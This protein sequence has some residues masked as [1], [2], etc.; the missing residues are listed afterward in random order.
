MGVDAR[1]TLA[2]EAGLLRL[3]R[4]SFGSENVRRGG[5]KRNRYRGIADTKRGKHERD[6]SPEKIGS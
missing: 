5:K 4:R 2:R 1:D 6:S 3:G